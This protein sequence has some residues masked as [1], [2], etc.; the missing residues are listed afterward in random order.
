MTGALFFGFA[1]AALSL[2]RGAVRAALNSLLL[3]TIVFLFTVWALLVA[4]APFQS[5]R[6]VAEHLRRLASPTDVLLYEG[7]LENAAGLPYYT[8]RQIH[9]LGAARGDLAFGSRFPEALGLFFPPESLPRLWRGPSRIFLLTDR[10]PERSAIHA[11]PEER[12]H[13]LL[14][15]HGKW[16]YSNRPG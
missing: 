11:V 12:R 6:G 14:L 3:G 2:W 13:L 10:P 4:I 5:V 1:A 9:L 15:D 8:G 16:L 7:Y